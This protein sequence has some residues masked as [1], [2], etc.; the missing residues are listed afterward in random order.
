[1]ENQLN[2]LRAAKAAYE[3]HAKAAYDAY[4]AAKNT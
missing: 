4:I 1:M 3:A 2:E